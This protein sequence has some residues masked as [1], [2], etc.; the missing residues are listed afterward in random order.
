MCVFFNVYNFIEKLTI[1]FRKLDSFYSGPFAQS[2][3]TLFSVLL[4]HK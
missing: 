4:R 3:T 1:L 2:E